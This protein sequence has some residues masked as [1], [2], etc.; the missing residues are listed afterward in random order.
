VALTER[1][2]HKAC[3]IGFD[4]VGVAEAGL[5]QSHARYVDWLARGR[6][7]SMSYLAR[8]D[9]V[10]RRADVR[11][12]LPQA[13]SVVVAGMNYYTSPPSSP[14]GVGVVARY[15][16]GDDYHEVI[17]DKLKQLVAFIEAEVGRPVAHK[18]C[19]DTSAVLEREWA[20]RAGLGWIGKNT[21]LINPRSGSWFLLGELL[22]DLELD[23]A[24]P[25]S[26]DH[27]GTC[28]RCIE[29]CP[30]HC[31]LPGRDL[32]ASR[33]ISYL[34]LELRGDIPE[35]LQPL[36]GDWAFGCDVCQ[37]VC[38]WNRFARPTH[39]PAFTPRRMTLDLRE[40]AEM[41]DEDFRTRFAHSA[42]RRAKR[43]GLA[44][45]AAIVAANLATKKATG[46]VPGG[47]GS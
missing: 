46:R 27:C 2:K 44:R 25:F 31:I 15:A 12:L 24:A 11:E 45:N 13:R 1:I 42:I 36:I 43:E 4:L 9:A 20:V 17:A 37:E 21:L 3:E 18:T 32:D 14:T 8:P 29:A 26:T 40:I 47:M 10:A 41:T 19:V 33:C 16:W 6:H 35:N 7:G 28:T 30:T 34:T 5:A 23:Y 39:Q 38:P 22:L